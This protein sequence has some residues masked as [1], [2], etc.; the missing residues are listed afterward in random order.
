M[1]GINAE[2]PSEISPDIV[3]TTIRETM[4]MMNPAMKY[5]CANC[6]R[7]GFEGER[8]KLVRTNFPMVYENTFVL[9]LCLFIWDPKSREIGRSLMS[10]QTSKMYVNASLALSALSF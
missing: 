9:Y 8:L 2:K 10:P 7:Y 4:G 1:V 3:T 5:V 6:Y